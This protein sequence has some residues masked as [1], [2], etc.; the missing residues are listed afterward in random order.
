MNDRE[1]LK[2]RIDSL[3]PSAVRFVARMVDSLS[4]PPKASVRQQATWL[5]SSADWIEYFGL[6]LSVHHGATVEPPC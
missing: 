6:S 2:E 4:C 1:R 3:S 5:T